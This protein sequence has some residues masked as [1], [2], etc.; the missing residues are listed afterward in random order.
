MYAA[1]R[2]S[3]PPALETRLA[4][5]RFQAIRDD[6]FGNSATFPLAGLLFA[7]DDER[8]IQR[9]RQGRHETFV[10]AGR[11]PKLV[12]EVAESGETE[13]AGSVALRVRMALLNDASK[14]IVSSPLPAGQSS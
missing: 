12:V 11:R 1:P 3:A 13:I 14:L 7:I 10:I 6:F 9:C 8:Q 2:E 5:T 4:G